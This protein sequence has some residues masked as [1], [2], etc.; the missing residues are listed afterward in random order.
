MRWVSDQS[1]FHYLPSQAPSIVATVQR[2]STMELYL[3]ATSLLPVVL[4][5]NMHPDY[6]ADTKLPAENR[7]G[8]YQSFNGVFMGRWPME[9]PSKINCPLPLGG[10][11]GPLPALCSADL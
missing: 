5:Y 10:E 3:D 2:V 9:T 6:D 7:F 8:T 1:L 11:G 4:D